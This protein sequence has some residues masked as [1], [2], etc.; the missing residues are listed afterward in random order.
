[1]LRTYSKYWMFFLLGSFLSITGARAGD[2]GGIVKAMAV[3][4]GSLHQIGVDSSR[5]VQDS[6]F[7]NPAYIGNLDT[8]YSVQNIVT[9]KINEAST[10]Y[11]R[12]AFNVTVRLRI[13]YTVGTSTVDS[14][15]RDFAVK[16]DSAA[17]Y[18]GRSSFVFNGARK[19][20]VKVLSVTSNVSTWDPVKALMV[21]NLL[22]TRPRFNFS[23]TNTVSSITVSPVVDTADELPVSWTAIL[24]ADQYDLEWTYV[25]TS[26]LKTGRYSVSPD[27]AFL[28][29]ATRATIAGTS[30]NIPLMYDDSGTVFI[31]VRPVQVGA[32]NSVV[33]AEWS[34]AAAT[35]VIGRYNFVGHQ[36]AFNWQSNISYAEEGKR[37]VVVQYYD[38]SLRSRQTVTKDNTTNNTIV[39]ETYY[40]YQGRPAIQ[41]MPAPTLNNVIH[42][43]AGFNVSINSPEYSQSNYDSLPGLGA[44]C[45]L[46]AGAMDSTAGASLYYSANN[47][48]RTAGMNQFI[49]S[50][51][52]YP[53]TETEYTPD[54]TGRISR[55]SGVGPDHQLGSGHETKYYYGTPD[56][57]ELDGLFGTEVGSH[58]HYF[59]NMV[60]DANGQYSVSYVDMHGRT[61]A[62]A[63]AGNTPVA[64]APLASNISRDVTENLVD[65]GSTSI[66]DLSIVN[67]KSLLVTKADTFNFHYELNP[68][69][70]CDA[71]CQQQQ[72]CYTCLYD[73]EITITDNCNNQLLPDGKAWD[74][75]VHNFSPGYTN[76]GGLSFN[77]SKILPEGNFLITKKLTVSRD[78]YNYYLSNVYLPGNTCRN[79]QQ[80]IDSVAHVVAA[81]NG[82]C[83][84]DCSTCRSKV[85]TWTDFWSSF[86]TNAGIADADTAGYRQ[87]AMTAYQNALS[88]CDAL[89]Q[90]KESD[91][92]DIR[93][94][95]L[96][97]MMPPYGQYA[98]TTRNVHADKYSIFYQ[99]ANDS[100]YVPTY[101]LS[102]IVYKDENGNPDKVYS[103]TSGIM[104]SPNSLT[105]EEFV[106]NFRPSWAEALLPY[107]PEYCKLQVMQ[108]YEASN[109]WDRKFEAVDD[110]ATALA[111][112]YM[113]S[114][115]RGGNIGNQSPWAYF[116]APPAD[117]D[118]LM[119]DPKGGALYNLR[120]EMWDKLYTY[121]PGGQG[122]PPLSMW[123]LAVI[124]VKCPTNETACVLKYADGDRQAHREYLDEMCDAD[125][126]MAW[127]NFRQ[128]YLNTKHDI[129]F[130]K[131][132]DPPN[133]LPFFIPP[134]CVPTDHRQYDRTP[135]AGKLF[136][137]QHQPQFT[138]ST[139]ALGYTSQQNL[140][141]ANTPSTANNAITDANNNIAA[142][143]DQN[144]HAY[145]AQWIQQLSV[146]TLY[147]PADVKAILIP[148]LFRMAR[149]ACDTEHPFGASSLPAD[150]T[151]PD[152]ASFRNFQDIINAYKASHGGTSDDL[153][154]NAEL[155]TE[156][157]PY[158]KQP[159]YGLKP[160]FSRPSDCECKL[161]TDLYNVYSLTGRSETFSAYLQRTQQVTIS[162]ADLTTLRTA[163]RN[164][165]NSAS[166][167]NFSH[168]IYLPPSMQC[169]VGAVCSDCQ[170]IRTLYTSYQ[171]DHA[172]NMPSYVNDADSVQ[173]QKNLLFQN[174]M[175]NRLGYQLQAWQYLQF[176]DTCSAH[177]DTT[178]NQQCTPRVIADTFHTGGTD[179]MRDMRRTPDGGY[180][181]VGSTTRSGRGTDAYIIRYDSTNNIQWAKTYGGTDDDHFFKVKTTSDGGYIAIGHTFSTNSVA[182]V[183]LVRLSA[184]GNT[185]W[186]KTFGFNSTQ[187]ERA[188]DI[189]QT[190]DGGF[191]F[192]GDHDINR[193]D[194]GDAWALAMR[195]DSAGNV[196]WGQQINAGKYNDGFG[197]R[198]SG[199]TLLITGRNYDGI[200]RDYGALYK[201]NDRTGALL[202]EF[203]YR[204]NSSQISTTFYDLYPTSFG[205]RITTLGSHEFTMDS[206][207]LGILDLWRNGSVFH[208]RELNTPPGTPVN[209]RLDTYNMAYTQDGGIIAGQKTLYNPNIFWTKADSAGNPQ[210][211]RWTTLAGVQRVGNIVQNADSSYAALCTDNGTAMLLRLSSTG[212]TGCYDS[213][214]STGLAALSMY[215]VSYSPATVDTLISNHSNST[216]DEANL[217]P[218]DS[219]I[220]CSIGGTN[221]Y[222]IYNGPTL[223]GKTSP[224]Y[225]PVTV[226]P[227]TAC[228]DSTFFSTSKGTVLYNYYT[229]SLTGNFEQEYLK[230]CLQAYKREVF[231]VT[232]SQ[233]EYHYTLYYYDQAGNLLK[234]VPPAGV[235]QHTD[236]NWLKQVRDARAAGTILTPSHTLVTDYRYNT[237]NQVVAQHTPDGGTSYFWYDRLGRL[238]LSQNA[239]QKAGGQYSYTKYDSIGR[240]TQVG[241]LVSGTAPTDAVTRSESSL[242]TWF[243]AVA[244]SADQITMTTYDSA[245]Y[246]AIPALAARNVRNRVAWT[247]LYNNYADMIAVPHNHATATYYS[248]DILGNVDTLVQ[249]Y[250]LGSMS[251]Q[252]NRFKKIVYDYDL[253]SGKVNRVSYQRGEPDAFYHTYYY[254]AENRIT[255]V[256]SS[257][258]S[259]N[260][261]NDAF[262]SYYAHGPLA[263]TVLGEQQVQGINY[264][265]TL[266]GWLKAINP[267]IYTGGAFTLRPDSSGNV[268]AATAY[269]VLLNYFNGDYVPVSGV[270]GPDNG[271][272]TAL[273]SAYR[274]LF[275][276]NISSMGVSVRKLDSALLYNYQYDQLNRLVHMDAW[277]RTGAA[278]NAISP[279][280]S[281]RENVSYDPNGNILTYRRDGKAATGL[282]MD[283]MRYVYTPGTN[284]LDHIYDTVPASS[285]YDDIDSQDPLN[286]HYDAI[287]QLVYD[288]ASR[289]SNITWTVYGKIASI[290]KG[291]STLLYTYDPSGNRISKS[292]VHGSDT[293]T[294]WYVRDAQGNVLSVYTYGDPAVH[295]RDLTQTELDIYGS[296]RLGILRP[297][298]DV[299]KPF[300]D[301]IALVPLLGT[302]DSITF[303]R[304]NKF[305]ELTNH[306]GNVLATISDKRFG[307]TTDSVVRYFIPDVVS[308]NDYYPFGML[309][310]GRSYAQNGNGYR[311]GFN[312]QEKSD[313]IKGPGN[314][315]TAEFWE[316]DPRAAIRWNLDPKPTVAQSPYV[317][318]GRNP[319]LFT[320]LKGDSIV[321]PTPTSN[322]DDNYRPWMPLMTRNVSPDLLQ[323]ASNRFTFHTFSD[324]PMSQA[325]GLDMNKDL[326]TAEI[327]KL[328]ANYTAGQ[329]FEYIRLHLGEFI[330]GDVSKFSAYNK[331][332]AAVWKSN[333]PNS[334]IMRF[335]GYV[336]LLVNINADDADVIT[337]NYVKS[338]NY[339]SWT[340]KPVTD[341]NIISNYAFWSDK[342]HPLGGNREFGIQKVGASYKFYIQGVDRV[343]GRFTDELFV[344]RTSG[345]TFFKLANTLWTQVMERIVERVHNLGGEATFNSQS[346]IS[347]QIDYNNSVRQEDQ[348][349][350]KNSGN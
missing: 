341:Y 76:P 350:V 89:C 33:A 106:Q 195:L 98:D 144:C 238:A 228:T 295:G 260:W 243:N 256:Q 180:V 252:L 52:A 80:Y 225:P 177:T 236:T 331:G 280:S 202:S 193:A 296:S 253:V 208:Y 162:D 190:S 214:V 332:E 60:R 311:Y 262:Y 4:D 218:G 107:H 46:H 245:N 167:I 74:T 158:D 171:H 181:M 28:N 24:G 210:W 112:G 99:P 13:Y 122:T 105:T 287:G 312:G 87:A 266:Q 343:W 344:G 151:D 134:S 159:A 142:Y 104:V 326:Y 234:T 69:S 165:T 197:I 258:D 215:T 14:I 121:Q 9:V 184:A 330:D 249:D 94:A 349:K 34:S 116:P 15:D 348:Q 35:P 26:V 207:H 274:P 263:R 316:Y 231:T 232:H 113:N 79:L 269:N 268:V 206:S 169:N 230:K 125:K 321:K 314:S 138:S 153:H 102:S 337:T 282:D 16:Y 111:R 132:I 157:A 241:Q 85:G 110:Y 305:F 170:T 347:K 212:T 325:S 10:V 40:D 133:N 176:L 288:G 289:I 42:Y 261:D 70:L 192:T 22:I 182:E 172:G 304:G 284:K 61:V 49:P 273:A 137:A 320:D 71:N 131:L 257:T 135:D 65:S 244:S 187:G 67:Q 19:V 147:D 283:K 240:I 72:V 141:N 47:P 279:T 108:T 55:Q 220:K 327:T 222:P 175:N 246:A 166:C 173:A 229:D 163:C 292:V 299:Y 109:L 156:P 154:C 37:K 300:S 323:L 303:N 48:L 338:D 73:L 150:R 340:F 148:Q 86:R 317:V 17:V 75:V 211:S 30:Y 11:L 174:Y 290:T 315:Y 123:S 191:A 213:T 334:A 194:M 308:A 43:T 77:F 66:Q 25:D 101:K 164:T 18:N 114:T 82:Q 161:I 29:N 203:H 59:K 324:Q 78:A 239:R 302:A 200:A 196:K 259:I 254:D 130:N 276:G 306:L 118:P 201:L 93:K 38:G 56:Q 8:A 298:R 247:A 127:R 294:T 126:D 322:T 328:P 235:D 149:L 227:I 188:F 88:A 336:R 264:A 84:P 91:D 179:V 267:D 140:Q 117:P 248:Y 145:E 333:N 233:S 41:V 1:M 103:Q 297:D 209:G 96:Q 313:E 100:N 115:T 128:M 183:L 204:P 57:N 7:F 54:N 309:Q 186:K 146:C 281:F 83:T 278:W 342:Q 178:A 286:Y 36:R 51:K 285:T 293:L 160:V 152:N 329:L 53:F 119:N 27:S 251:N 95:M 335:K 272:S 68:E 237:L 20:T 21:E 44:F 139:S 2:G 217:T 129:F 124:M 3:L 6:A 275:N 23:C 319:I 62:T 63:L 255:N 226:P 346:V 50:A 5:T 291:D 198:Q 339:A 277:R 250:R 265:Y 271:V 221:C 92:N 199:D 216:F 39:A 242:S 136:A 12:S 189:I 64:L 81:S 58:L 32:G 310:P 143:Y 223:C 205:Y 31:R 45:D 224:V 318:F 155:V 97:D 168:P 307:V 185:V 345:G 219:T 301:S 120:L 90:D 270:P